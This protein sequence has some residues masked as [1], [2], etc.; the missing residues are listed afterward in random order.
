MEIKKITVTNSEE[1]KN[2]LEKDY[3]Y[4]IFGSDITLTSGI[5]ISS[6]KRVTIDGNNYNYTGIST[7]T[8][9]DTITANPENK[10]IIIKNMNVTHTNTHGIIYAKGDHLYDNI[11]IIYDNITF[12]GTQLSYNPFGK[13]KII[14]CN[15]TIENKNNINAQEVAECN[16]IEIGGNTTILSNSTTFSMFKFRNDTF[17]P[18]IKILPNSIVNITSPHTELINNT[19]NLNLHVM[20]NATFNLT[21]KNGMGYGN[22]GCNDVLIDESANFNFEET[23]HYNIPMWK[24]NGKFEIKE[25]SNVKIINTYEN[26]PD[27]NYNLHFKGSSEIIIDKPNSLILYNKNANVIYSES[28]RN[29]TL[30][31][32]RI[33][34]WDNSTSLDLAGTLNNLPDYAYYKDT[35]TSYIKGSILNDT[36]ITY[37]DIELNNFNLLNKKQLSIGTISTNIYPLNESS[38]EISGYTYPLTSILIN[39]NIIESD[40]N[41]YFSHEIK[42][43]EITITFNNN[44]IYKTRNITLPYNGELSLISTNKIEFDLNPISL[45]PVILPKK[46]PFKILVIDSRTSNENWHLYLSLINQELIGAIKF[47]GISLNEVPTL[48]YEDNSKV[49]EIIFDIDKDILLN[50]ENNFLE[51]NKYYYTRIILNID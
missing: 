45:D 23:G 27:D 39:N 50:L 37:T 36:T 17:S 25:N 47:K 10:T 11:E 49:K 34:M 26:T 31:F 30:N 44:F 12:N 5:T 38:T 16:Q 46:E 8:Q 43:Q 4:I 19:N 24:I 33:N 3:S 32:S 20:N 51:A 40:N 21:T 28:E 48:I 7:N 22:S 42:A 2:A 6:K 29:F 1:L 14:D 15:I 41:G 9:T 18:F 35:S 13:I